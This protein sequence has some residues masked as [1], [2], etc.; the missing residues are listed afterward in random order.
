MENLIRGIISLGIEERSCVGVLSYNRMEWNFGFWSVVCANCV[1]VGIYMTNTAEEIKHIIDDCGMRAIFV[2]NQE[3]YDK[4]KKIKE[5][6][7]ESIKSL[8]YIITFETIT[9]S[10]IGIETLTLNTLLKIGLQK[11]PNLRFEKKKRSKNIK[12]GQCCIIVYTSGTTGKSK[13]VMLNHDNI[14]FCYN[15][16]PQDQIP[17]NPRL[18]SYLPCS[19]VAGLFADVCLAFNWGAS[20]FFAD[21]DALKNS[22]PFFLKT[23]KPHFFL[24][25]P[26]VF[27]KIKLKIEEEVEKSGFFR[28]MVFQWAKRQGEREG[29]W[30]YEGRKASW[31]YFLAKRVFLKMKKK[32]GFEDCREFL[33]GAAP[34]DEDIRDFF[35]SLDIFVNNLYGLSENTFGTGLMPED[36]KYYYAKSCGRPYLENS[37]KIDPVTKEIKLK[38]R[39]L[40]MGYLNNPEKTLS[41]LD[42]DFFFKTGDT[43]F[44]NKTKNLFIIGRIKELII[45]AGGENIAPAPIE[46]LILQKIGQFCSFAVLVGNNRKFLS[47]LIVIKNANSPLE[48]PIDEID[49]N[50]R[51]FLRKKNI[52][53]DFISELK[54][55]E[56]FQKLKA[57]VEEAVFFANEK[58][59]SNASKIRKWAVL[60]RDFSLPTGELTPTM[61]LKRSKVELHFKKDIDELYL[62][63]SL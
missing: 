62:V 23:V 13:G 39:G 17:P 14:T 61:K 50:A 57:V 3:Q 33:S 36:K 47:L 58:S 52:F 19:H 54:I 11:N 60:N 53:C 21:E 22:L 5:Q 1:N 56:N 25:V 49:E 4:I 42:K 16:V 20:V 6:N 38:G 15:N 41:V 12:T 59:V 31:K 37:V 51:F 45:T 40:F 27:E 8:K 2:E 18:I 28:K 29:L 32:I 63:P 24:G 48:V 9:P 26:R 30:K 10:K 55:G 7:S 34:M 43:G 46:N 44:L 35:L